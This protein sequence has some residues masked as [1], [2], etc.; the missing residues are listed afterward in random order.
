VRVAYIDTSAVVA[1]AFDEHQ[2]DRVREALAGYDRLFSSDLLEAELRSVFHRERRPW[3]DAWVAGVGGSVRRA[4]WDR[5]STGCCPP[6]SSGA[7]T[8]GTCPVPSIWRSSW[9][10]SRRRLLAF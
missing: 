4:G 10:P 5:C 3:S 8:C 7:P 1:L 6:G 2:G 9:I